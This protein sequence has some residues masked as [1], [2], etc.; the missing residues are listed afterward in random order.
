MDLFGMGGPTR[1]NE[2]PASIALRFIETQASLPRQVS[3]LVQRGCLS[4]I[5]KIV[6]EVNYAF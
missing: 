4:F 2:S 1:G 3:S 5:A 6:S